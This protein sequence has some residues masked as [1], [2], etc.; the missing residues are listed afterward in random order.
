MEEAIEKMIEFVCTDICQF[1]LLRPD[2]GDR[3]E[4]CETCGLIEHNQKII[5]CL[6]M[7]KAPDQQ[8]Q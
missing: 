5:K 7:E 2:M 4:F 6:E 3:A 1:R 8:K